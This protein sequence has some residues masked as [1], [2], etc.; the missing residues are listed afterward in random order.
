MVKNFLLKRGDQLSFTINFTSDTPVSEMVFGVKKKYSDA[1]YTILKSLNRIQRNVIFVGDSYLQGYLPTGQ[2]K[3]WGM[4][5]V[6]KSGVATYTIKSYQG[7][8]F[9]EET[10]FVNRRFAQ[11]LDSV[12]ASDSVTDIIVCGGYNDRNATKDKVY[13]GFKE[14]CDIAKN[15]FKNAK[16]RCSM[17]GWSDLPER[18]D[19]LRR[20][21]SWYRECCQLNNVE[22]ME[23]PQ[24]AARN[25]SYFTVDHV[26]PNLAGQDAIGTAVA[27]YIPTTNG[28]GITK[29]SNT[30]Y[31]IIIPSSDTQNLDIANYVYDLRMT[32]YENK[33][34]PLSGKLM[35]KETVFEV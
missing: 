2:I 25:A 11:L 15:K 24:K 8:G 35:V 12:S 10:S 23:D 27:S 31:Q 1:N 4:F 21:E 30:K 19:S 22:Y 33:S 34:T 9:S 14:F 3:N 20:C 29:I 28:S 18:Y 32:L 5:A 16:V 26:H 6:D 13:A 17:I 7:A